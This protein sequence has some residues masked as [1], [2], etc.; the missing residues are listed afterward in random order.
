M[1]KNEYL[2]GGCTRTHECSTDKMAHLCKCF[3]CSLNL[4]ILSF[5]YLFNLKTFRYFWSTHINSIGRICL[6]QCCRG[7]LVFCES[8]STAHLPGAFMEFVPQTAVDISS[9]YG[10]FQFAWESSI[11]CKGRWDS[12]T[13]AVFLTIPGTIARTLPAITW[14]ATTTYGLPSCRQ[15]KPANSNRKNP[16]N[17][18]CQN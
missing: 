6:L 5:H 17:I 16:T 10:S 11:S 9:A 15:N 14:C 7:I 1:A 18:N 8:L 12:K 13:G 4:Q 2:C 3:G